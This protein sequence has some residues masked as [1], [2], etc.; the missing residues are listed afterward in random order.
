MQNLV[1]KQDCRRF[2]SL[3]AITWATLVAPTMS[4]Q[5]SAA[6]HTALSSARTLS[7][8][9][10]VSFDAVS[11][12]PSE[13]DGPDEGGGG[14]TSY[15]YTAT[16]IA[17]RTVIMYAY[18]PHPYGY[19][20]DRLLSVP[21]WMAKARYDI[22]AKV[23]DATE[24]EWKGLSTAQRRERVKP[25][26]RAMLE[27]RCKL[28]LHSTTTEAPI[29]ALMVGRHG[30]KLKISNPGELLPVGR[31]KLQLAATGEGP[32]VIVPF[33]PGEKQQDLFFGT[34]M[35]SLAAFMSNFSDRPV[36]DRTGLTGQ[37]DFVLSKR[38]N[39]PPPTEHSN[40][41]ASDPDPASIFDVEGLGLVLKPAK[42]LAET[43]VIDHI[44][45]PS[46]N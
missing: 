29:Y 17:L 2:F 26:L 4:A 8:A 20:R 3:L 38:E 36:L 10:T 32:G 35:A 23:D 39:S 37:Y 24:K 45:Q 9:K 28:A 14:V 22:K 12:R 21:P 43:L 19:W 1:L 7:D 25:M 46:E 30:P 40:V 5:V 27:D 33:I 31:V 44:E 6:P 16:G 41:S 15:G 34:P 42:G 11:I 18:Y 13:H